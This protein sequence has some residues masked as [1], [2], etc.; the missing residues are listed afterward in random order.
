MRKGEETDW[1]KEA[2]KD[3]EGKLKTRC[4]S[5]RTTPRSQNKAKEKSLQLNQKPEKVK[6]YVRD[7]QGLRMV[8]CGV[9]TVT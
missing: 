1:K 2:S 5:R 3:P 8:M 9:E 6:Y 4:W 7:V